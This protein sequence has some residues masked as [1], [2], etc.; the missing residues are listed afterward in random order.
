MKQ[1]VYD[2]GD[3]LNPSNP[4]ASAVRCAAAA[5]SPYSGAGGAARRRRPVALLVA[6]RSCGRECAPWMCLCSVCARGDGTSPPQS[7]VAAVGA[8]RIKRVSQSTWASHVDVRLCTCGDD[9]ASPH[10]SE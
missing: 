6:V 3:A 4:N 2:S 1:R 8:A 10:L 7:P 9:A 5:W